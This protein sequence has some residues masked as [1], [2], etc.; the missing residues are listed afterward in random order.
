M[1]HHFPFNL[2]KKLMLHF[3]I[4]FP[5]CPSISYT[6]KL[7][8]FLGNF[9]GT[10]GE[11]RKTFSVTSL[12]FIILGLKFLMFLQLMLFFKSRYH[13]KG[14]FPTINITNH[15]VSVRNWS[16]NVSKSYKKFCEFCLWFCVL[17]SRRKN[18][19]SCLIIS[20]KEFEILECVCL[21]KVSW[22]LKILIHYNPFNEKKCQDLF[23]CFIWEPISIFWTSV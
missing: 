11:I 19:N 13:Q 4:E 20:M 21:R 22:A 1:T 16:S 7:I 12:D 3:K 6:K 18:S 14:M 23:D 9:L 15:T 5:L 2:D 8:I 17:S 10:G